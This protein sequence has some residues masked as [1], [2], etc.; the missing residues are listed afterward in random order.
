MM[1]HHGGDGIHSID[2][3]ICVA[4][5]GWCLTMLGRLLPLS[6]DLI[7]LAACKD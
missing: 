1:K 6:D 4:V 3:C 5:V 7:C 2:L